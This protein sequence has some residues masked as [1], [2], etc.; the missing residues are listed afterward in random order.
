[1]ILP[2]HQPDDSM[3]AILKS[4]VAH[5]HPV[6]PALRKLA[7]ELVQ[8]G[9]EVAA[10]LV[11]GRPKPGKLEHQQANGVSHGL[12]RREECLREKIRVQVTLVRL[13]GHVAEPVQFWEL[14]IE[15]RTIGW[16]YG[17]N[18]AWI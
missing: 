8:V 12:A 6:R 3:A 17:H 16:H 4:T 10:M 5:L 7:Q 2:R 18:S 9:H 15:T 1:M 11:V 13:P 14:L